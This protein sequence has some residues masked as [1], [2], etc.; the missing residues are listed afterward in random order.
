MIDKMPRTGRALC[1]LAAEM[2]E[3]GIPYILANNHYTNELVLQIDAHAYDRVMEL[4]PFLALDR[5]PAF[6]HSYRFKKVSGA[7]DVIVEE[8][9][10]NTRLPVQRPKSAP[11]PR[12]ATRRSR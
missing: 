12:R 6:G 5:R 8:K 4:Y 1:E 10:V 7:P 11:K 2:C 3:Q 9:Y